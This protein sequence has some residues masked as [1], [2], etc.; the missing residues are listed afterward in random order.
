MLGAKNYTQIFLTGVVL[1]G[2]GIRHSGEVT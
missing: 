2:G 1:P